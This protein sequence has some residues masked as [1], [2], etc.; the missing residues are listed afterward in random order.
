MFGETEFP[1]R[2]SAE[3]KGLVSRILHK[4]PKERPSMYEI[5][6]HQWF[7]KYRTSGRY[8]SKEIWDLWERLSGKEL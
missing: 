3:I 8:I 5:E 4:N 6:C 1:S 2:V 7:K